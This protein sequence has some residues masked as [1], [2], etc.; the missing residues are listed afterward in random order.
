MVLVV[1]M[2]LLVACGR[3]RPSR[4]RVEAEI[5]ECLID[6]SV[7]PYGWVVAEGPGPYDLPE[8]V[9]PGRALGGVLVA[10]FQ[11]VLG[12]RADHTLF[13]Y[14][15][16]HEAKKEFERQMPNVF[17]SAGRLVPW[18]KINISSFRPAANQMEVRCTVIKGIKGTRIPI[19]T[20]LAQ[21]D[22]ILS[23][24]STWS[25]PGYMSEEDFVHVLQAIDERM[26]WCLDE[27]VPQLVPN[28]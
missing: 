20:A 22:T 26:K 13:I 11:P 1:L 19:C 18:V 16:K 5:Q 21:Y 23:I 24:F 9:L 27:K 2:L 28:E 6:V 12:A 15:N 8:R 7:L 17:F 3:S 14:P 25:A 4:A 10:F